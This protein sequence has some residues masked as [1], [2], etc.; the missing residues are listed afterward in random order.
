M[1]EDRSLL[2]LNIYADFQPFNSFTGKEADNHK[3]ILMDTCPLAYGL[4]IQIL[5]SKTK[6]YFYQFNQT[7]YSL[8]L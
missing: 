8:N 7:S 3:M 1:T 6:V 4:D 2:K 5:I